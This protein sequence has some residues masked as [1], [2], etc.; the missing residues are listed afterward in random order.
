MARWRSQNTEIVVWNYS[1][2]GVFTRDGRRH[3]R[4]KEK[5]IIYFQITQP[6]I[7]V[8]LAYTTVP[9]SG[10]VRLCVWQECRW[11]FT[12]PF[13]MSITVYSPIICVGRVDKSTDLT[14][15]KQWT[16]RIMLT[17]RFVSPCKLCEPDAPMS[18][19]KLKTI[20]EQTKK[21]KKQNDQPVIQNGDW[22]FFFSLTLFLLFFSLLLTNTPI[23]MHA[24]YVRSTLTVAG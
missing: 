9:T 1:C 18:K 20:L 15:T 11:S 2:K 6:S 16:S 8:T 17:S 3:R 19:S 21:K 10:D 12:V 22:R 7:K 14:L 13:Y 4:P 24:Y 5:K 23:P